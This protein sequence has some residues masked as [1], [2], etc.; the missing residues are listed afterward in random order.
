MIVL[1]RLHP[2]SWINISDKLETSAKHYD[3]HRKIW[4]RTYCSYIAGWDINKC[5]RGGTRL[6]GKP[7]VYWT[8]T[9][10]H[11]RLNR[12]TY[13]SVS[14]AGISGPLYAT[15]LCTRIRDLR[16]ARLDSTAPPGAMTV[17]YDLRLHGLLLFMIIQRQWRQLSRVSELFIVIGF[18]SW[19][20]NCYRR[21]VDMLNSCLL[22][23]SH[24]VDIL[25]SCPLHTPLHGQLGLPP[26]THFAWLSRISRIFPHSANTS[27]VTRFVPQ[28]W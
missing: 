10:L 1:N 8:F 13:T 27:C 11:L 21:A 3:G 2:E 4:L 7:Y 18:L 6:L 15:E 17:V 9:V 26:V 28:F 25:N 20:I 19:P 24:A 14:P 16:S 23:T 22:H 5:K 12:Y